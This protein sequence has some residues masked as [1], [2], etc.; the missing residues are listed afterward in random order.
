MQRA[1]APVH[2]DV[3][4]D[5]FRHEKLFLCFTRVKDITTCV[6]RVC[7]IYQQLDFLGPLEGERFCANGRTVSVML[8]RVDWQSA[9]R[10]DILIGL[11]FGNQL[12]QQCRSDK[13]KTSC[14]VGWPSKCGHSPAGWLSRQPQMPSLCRQCSRMGVVY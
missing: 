4:S 5:Q 7:N 2:H 9:V 13:E 3:V 11:L 6:L 12:S 1:R 8:G 14:T 10:G